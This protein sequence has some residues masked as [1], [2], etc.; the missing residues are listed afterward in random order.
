MTPKPR[1]AVIGGL[2]IDRIVRDGQ[3]FD[4]VAGGNALYAALGARLHGAAASLISVAGHDYPPEVLERLEQAG[5]DVSLVAHVDQPSIRLWILYEDDG[6]RQIHYR[7]GSTDLTMIKQELNPDSLFETPDLVWDG[8]HMA[9]LP[10]RLQ[11]PIVQRLDPHDVCVTLDSIE[12]DGDVGGD[13]PSYLDDNMLAHVSTFLPS[14]AE[15]AQIRGTQS[16]EETLTGMHEI[17]L[18]HLVIKRGELGAEVI[19]LSTGIATLV[20]TAPTTRI[21]DPTGA[22]DVFCGAYL[23]A[24]LH[25]K[26]PVEAAIAGAAAASCVLEDVGAMHLI[27]VSQ[28]ELRNRETAITIQPSTGSM[29]RES[30]ERPHSGPTQ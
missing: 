13:L 27:D 10:V 21:V 4:N 15:F 22:G 26:D 23:A 29:R 2:T 7:T 17:G 6:Q 18:E 20:S 5:I 8:V 16:L 11:R 1:A 14:Q 3:V 12:A 24:S 19:D 9:A 30:M 28:S 25:D